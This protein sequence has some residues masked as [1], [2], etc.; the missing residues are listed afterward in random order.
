MTS[1]RQHYRRDAPYFVTAETLNHR[2]VFAAP[3]AADLLV[4]NLD[5][6]RDELGFGLL[7]FV[8]LPDR[9][10]LLLVPGA[11]VALG[12][13]VRQVK[14]GFTHDWNA[15]EGAH[16]RIWQAGYYEAL[17]RSEQQ[18]KRWVEFIESAPVEAALAQAT[19]DYAYS[20][21][22]HGG[23]VKADPYA[24]IGAPLAQDA[25]GELEP[26]LTRSRR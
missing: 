20:S 16:R 9:L 25:A 7:A 19:A 8:I 3:A 23:L 13:L 15:I 2:P 5:L 21:A 17:V 6:L 26:L 18:L 10:H 4:A 14:A 22:S 11:R 12:R 24:V 1:R